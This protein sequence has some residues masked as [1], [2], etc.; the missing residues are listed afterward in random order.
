VFVIAW[1][2]GCVTPWVLS[3]TEWMNGWSQQGCATVGEM[4]TKLTAW[5]KDLEDNK[6]H[7]VVS[8]GG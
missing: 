3:K 8:C 7:P 4:K 6:V 2:L 5:R 1:K